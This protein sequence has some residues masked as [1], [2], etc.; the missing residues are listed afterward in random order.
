MHRTWTDGVLRF[1]YAEPDELGDV[2]RMLAKERVCE[3]VYFGP[4]SPEETRQ[5]FMPLLEPMQASLRSGETP[6]NHVFTIRKVDNSTFVGN[7]ALLP[8]I[9]GAGNYTIGYQLDD[10]HWR[11]GYGMRACEFVIWYGFVQLQARRL[12][13]DTLVSNVGSARIM[14][15][16][17]FTR[18][19]VR[20]SY[21]VAGQRVRDD[22][23]FGL[24]R[25]DGGIDLEEMTSRFRPT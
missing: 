22:L 11:K 18:E 10:V 12:S 6:E 5:Y 1:S 16:C 14:E 7:C 20:K 15:K 9:F 17:G 13:G 19:G 24:L 3:H 4:N 21:Y 2:A 8:V 23:L 25:E